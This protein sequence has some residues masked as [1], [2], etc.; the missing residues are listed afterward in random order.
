MIVAVSPEGA[1]GLHGDIPW[2]HPG[3]QRRFKR[4][5]LGHAIVMGRKTWESIEKRALPKR[6]NVVVSR[7]NVD[8]VEHYASVA[9]AV[10]AIE[11][12]ADAPN[13]I[14]IVGGAGIYRE[15]ME[16]AD[17]ID[18]T[19]VPEHVTHPDAVHFPA[20]DE[21]VWRAGPIVTHEDEPE[22]LRREFTRV[23]PID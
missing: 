17:V 19:Y 18:V 1:I 14:W 2:N 6:R 15:G 21:H 8:G 16:L 7:S 9:D 12:S 3:D 4:V 5:T 10:R 20:I 23:H 13:E 11:A 22:L